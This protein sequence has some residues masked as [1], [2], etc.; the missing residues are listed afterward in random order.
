MN[1]FKK[2]LASAAITSVFLT[3]CA[4][5][6]LVIHETARTVGNSNHELIAGG[7]QAGFIAKWNYGLS[8]NLDIG[9]HWE[10]LSLGVRAKYAFENK[11]AGWSFATALGTG[12]S[13]GGSHYYADFIASHKHGA[14]EPYMTLRA[15]HVKTDPVDFADEN[16]GSLDFT[17]Q[18]E[19]YNYG[20]FIFRYKIL[21]FAPLAFVC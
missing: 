14:W 12:G 9:L 13:V 7:G 10:S 21:V 11:E 2:L 8:E 15:V 20:Q 16:T 3:S 6:P 1:N 5:G 17:I 18:K 4:V 19:Q